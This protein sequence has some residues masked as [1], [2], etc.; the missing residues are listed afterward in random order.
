LPGSVAL[1]RLTLWKIRPEVI[2]NRSST[3]APTSRPNF[4]LRLSGE[5]PAEAAV[6]RG[7]GDEGGAG[8]GESMAVTFA[9]VARANPGQ[10]RRHVGNGGSKTLR[11]K[12]VERGLGL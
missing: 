6:N 12:S 10:W 2:S 8:V 9:K 5:V 4:W 7:V 11:K 1:P 3:P